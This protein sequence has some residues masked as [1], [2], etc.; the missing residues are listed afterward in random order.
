MSEPVPQVA[1]NDVA[2][3]YNGDWYSPP[4]VS[5][6]LRMDGPSSGTLGKAMV[7]NIDADGT[8]VSASLRATPVASDFTLWQDSNNGNFGRWPIQA[9]VAKS[10]YVEFDLGTAL[11]SGGTVQNGPCTL[12]LEVSGLPPQSVAPFQIYVYRDEVRDIKV[13]FAPDLATA[14]AFAGT[15]LNIAQRLYPT[16]GV[17]IAVVDTATDMIVAQVGWQRGGKASG[18]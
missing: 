15:W 5:G 18:F 6:E 7:S 8:D 14:A 16:V 17:T 2:F 13:G 4:P 1:T 11:G 9:V 12:Q 10:S 3:N